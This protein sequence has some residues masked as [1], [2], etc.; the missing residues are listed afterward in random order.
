M[1]EMVQLELD[2]IINQKL[3]NWK[4][5]IEYDSYP[6]SPRNWNNLGKFLTGKWNQYV[7]NEME[8]LSLSDIYSGNIEKDL[9]SLHKLGYIAFPVSV[10]DHSG[11]TIFLG[12]ANDWDSGIIGFYTF[13]IEEMKKEYG[14]KKMTKKRESFLEKIAESEIKV[15]DDYVQGNVYGFTLSKNGEEIDSCWG[16]Y[17]DNFLEDM[18]DHFPTEFTNNFT[19]DEIK[20]MA[21]MPY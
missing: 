18:R 14:W 5:K 4:L 1:T 20:Q 7:S 13:N 9:E 11:W 3:E 6:D 16:F 12:R 8:D 19:L 2:G 10:Y 15:F 21:I 17:G